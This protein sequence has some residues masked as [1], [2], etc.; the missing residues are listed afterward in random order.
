MPWHCPV[1][2]CAMSWGWRPPSGVMTPFP[3]ES[4][5]SQSGAQHLC[6]NHHP[7]CAAGCRGHPWEVQCPQG[8]GLLLTPVMGSPEVSLV[9]PHS[10]PGH[11]P[12]ALNSI[13]LSGCHKGHITDQ[14]GITC[15]A[16]LSSKEIKRD[17]NWNQN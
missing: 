13:Y 8:P 17:K 7:P 10:L 14:A 4:A 1:L 11:C 6:G 15:V 9:P 3:M 2:D 16:F 5:L 12:G